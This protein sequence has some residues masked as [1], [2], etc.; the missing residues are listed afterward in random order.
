MIAFQS[1]STGLMIPLNG[2]SKL[3]LVLFVVSLMF[4]QPAL[5]QDA[6]PQDPAAGDADD[7]TIPELTIKKELVDEAEVKNF[8][9]KAAK[10][11]A[12]LRSGGAGPSE[13]KLIQDAVRLLVLRLSLVSNRNNL[14]KLVDEVVRDIELHA[15]GAAKELMLKEVVKRCSEL[16]DNHLAVRINAAVLLNRLNEDPGNRAKRIRPTPYIPASGPL[17]EALKSP[18]QHEAVKVRAVAG[19][20][21]ICDDALPK[22]NLRYD[23]TM[24]IIAEIES[25]R[26]YHWYYTMLLVRTLP[27]TKV[28]YNVNNLPVTTET[29]MRTMM[30]K[31]NQWLVRA[32]AAKALGRIDYD[33]NH[34]IPF[35]VHEISKFNME[36]TKRYN[37][38]LNQIQWPLC[39][40]RIY[41]AF[42]PVDEE[43]QA[44]GQGL[45]GKVEKVALR[46]YQTDIDNAYQENLKVVNAVISTEGRQQV[47]QPAIDSLADWVQNNPPSDTKVTP[48]AQPMVA[49][50]IAAADAPKR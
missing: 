29:V 19:L 37:G 30:T 39:Y 48:N 1:N 27:S 24:A 49:A 47:P 15:K 2:L 34:N 40:L 7:D 8:R 33:G 13:S 46:K 25:N 44:N 32:E 9:T 3:L 18:T 50:G 16:M 23:I 22:V 12:A 26:K 35:V 45:L 38:A 42:H 10:Y 11:R 14:D 41:W 17:L 31:K 6:P 5:A 20:K 36:L 21:R 43:E 28:L 4:I